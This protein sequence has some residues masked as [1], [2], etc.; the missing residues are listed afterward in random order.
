MSL[1]HVVNSAK[2]MKPVWDQ[3]YVGDLLFAKFCL[4][5]GVKSYSKEM[6]DKYILNS[7]YFFNK[8]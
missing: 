5:V 4:L 7:K 3:L 8:N 2:L 6:L 1:K